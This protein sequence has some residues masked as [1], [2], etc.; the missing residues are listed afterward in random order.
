MATYDKVDHPMHYT[1]GDIECIDAIKS[2]LGL[3]GFVDYCRGNVIKYVWRARQKDGIES[4]LAKA[5]KYLDF[6]I[7]ALEEE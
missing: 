2:A 1:S 4:D 7:D 3:D 5:R 6:A